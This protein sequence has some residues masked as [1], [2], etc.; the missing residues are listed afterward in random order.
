MWP[1]LGRYAFAVGLSWAG[2]LL[3]LAGLIVWVW[4]RA[5]QVRAALAAIENRSGTRT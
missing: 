1:D 5:G 3:L 2:S 4:V